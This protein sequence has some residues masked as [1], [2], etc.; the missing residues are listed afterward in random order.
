MKTKAGMQF[1]LTIFL[2][3]LKLER[4]A[5]RAVNVAFESSSKS[6]IVTCWSRLEIGF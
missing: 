2:F 4:A 3:D 1:F 5:S 6:K